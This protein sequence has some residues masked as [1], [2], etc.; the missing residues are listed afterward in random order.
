M[1]AR[2][3]APPP[4]IENRDPASARHCCASSRRTPATPASSASPA[5][6]ARA[7]A[8]SSTRWPRDLRREGKTVGILAVDP[9]SRVTGGAILGDRIRMQ[10]HHADPGVFIRSMATRGA[11]GGLARATADLA[12]LHGRRRQGLRHHRNRG[13]GPGRSR[14]RRP[15]ATSRWWCWSPAWATM[16]RPS[17]PASWKSPT[18]SS[19]TRPT[20]PAPTRV[21]RDV[22]AAA[23][24]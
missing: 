12:R 24:R 21:E 18:S 8:R 22:E 15:G 2:W 13:R 17:K 5:R 19:S 11:S 16:C 1:R 14:D 23:C 4:A 20:S 3:P 6:P 10:Q 7:R 9:T